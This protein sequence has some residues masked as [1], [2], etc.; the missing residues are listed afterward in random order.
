M[1][2]ITYLKTHYPTKIIYANLFENY[3]WAQK[4]YNANLNKNPLDER[5]E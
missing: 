3:D 1:K 4:N 5:V 2:W